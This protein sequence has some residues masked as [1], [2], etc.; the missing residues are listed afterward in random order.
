MVK[1]LAL[2]LAGLVAGVTLVVAGQWPVTEVVYRNEQPDNVTYTDNSAHHLGLL[3]KSSLFC[4]PEHQLV[5]CRVPGFGFAHTVGAVGQELAGSDRSSDGV[6]VRFTSGHELFIPARY[7]T[8][9][10]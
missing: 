7:F 3:R 2:L 1:K 10:R 4:G 9:G 6:R 5:T 8:H